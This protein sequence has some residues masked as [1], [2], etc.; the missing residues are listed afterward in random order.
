MKNKLIQKNI[1][2]NLD[3]MYIHQSMIIMMTMLLKDLGWNIRLSGC[4]KRSTQTHCHIFLA[5]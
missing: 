4:W 2:P 5:L 3:Q 1:I